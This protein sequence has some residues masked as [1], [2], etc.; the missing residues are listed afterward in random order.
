MSEAH[1]SSA[2][3]QAGTT[4]I[5]ILVASALMLIVIVGIMPLFPQSYRQTKA[6]GRVTQLNHLVSLKAEQLR[7]LPSDDPDLDLGT[8]PVQ[9]GDSAGARFYPVEAWPEEYSLRWRVLGGP[10][11][12]TGSPE[13]EMKILVIEATFGVRYLAGGDAIFTDDSVAVTYQTFLTEG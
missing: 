8:H 9:K 11:D 4:L 3:G 2:A 12:G 13:P 1:P 5:E 6:A 7:A 10:T